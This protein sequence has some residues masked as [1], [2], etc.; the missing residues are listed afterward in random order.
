MSRALGGG[1]ERQCSPGQ[2]GPEVQE[3]RDEEG[4]VSARGEKR[5]TML[6]STMTTKT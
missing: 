2:M 4:I 1:A 6:R 5:E 3:R